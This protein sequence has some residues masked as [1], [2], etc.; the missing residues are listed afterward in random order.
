MSSGLNLVFKKTEGLIYSPNYMNK[1]LNISQTY[2]YRIEAPAG[3]R[4][5]LA[6]SYIN[7]YPDTS[8]SV[9]SLSIY[10]G[11]NSNGV[12]TERRCGRNSAE[13]LS[14]SN[15]VFLTYITKADISSLP[16]D[17]GFIVFYA[18]GTHGKMLKLLK[19]K[20]GVMLGYKKLL[21][22]GQDFR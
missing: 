5:Y 2:T 16:A 11:A 13:F 21:C 20:T 6:V 19:R 1:Q 7:F 15:V 22:L 17:H 9:T 8:C 12:P 14:V 18:S 4:I 3:L 10:D